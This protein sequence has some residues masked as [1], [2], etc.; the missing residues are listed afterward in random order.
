MRRSCQTPFRVGRPLR[1]LTRQRRHP[2]YATQGTPPGARAGAPRL[3][4]SDK[5]GTGRYVSSQLELVVAVADR[6]RQLHEL[7]AA[8]AGL[9][10]ATSWPA[11][12]RTAKPRQDQL[13]HTC[14][15]STR[16]TSPRSVDRLTWPTRRRFVRQIVSQFVQAGVY[17]I[18][19]TSS[20]SSGT[21][22]TVSI[23]ST[24]DLDPFAAAVSRC[25]I[26]GAAALRVTPAETGAAVLTLVDLVL[27]H[28]IAAP[29][30]RSPLSPFS[31][32]R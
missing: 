30:G 14:S 12:V 16:S 22:S 7:V 28:W 17:P 8:A 15:S 21:W 2:S 11:T 1:A 27:R 20:S 6:W 24:S 9:R 32:R 13:E 25:L 26:G 10:P 18:G 5:P 31:A 3:W 19:V 29:A 4:R 23:V